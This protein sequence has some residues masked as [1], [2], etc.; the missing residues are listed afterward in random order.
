M[1]AQLRYYGICQTPELLSD[2]D[3]AFQFALLKKIRKMEA[4][5]GGFRSEK[6]GF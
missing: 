4:E 6:K 5:G 1:E 3:W 2:E